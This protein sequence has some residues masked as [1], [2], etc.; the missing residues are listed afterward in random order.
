MVNQNLL[1]VLSIVAVVFLINCLSCDAGATRN[2]ELDRGNGR[3]NNAISWMK[4]QVRRLK[5]NMSEC[6]YFS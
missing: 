3:I 4:K 1:L 5:K 6:K 2:K